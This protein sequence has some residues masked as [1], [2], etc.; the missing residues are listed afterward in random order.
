MRSEGRMKELTKIQVVE[1]LLALN[2]EY[3]KLKG[4]LADRRDELLDSRKEITKL[5]E[6]LPKLNAEVISARNALEFIA[7][8]TL[9]YPQGVEQVAGQTA[10]VKE[11]PHPN[12]AMIAWAV[13]SN[14]I[15]ANPNTDSRNFPSYRP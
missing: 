5:Q 8:N 15:F 9:T 3:A 12:G 14:W 1:K 13:A 10:T 4:D 11:E 2:G 6:Q 7:S